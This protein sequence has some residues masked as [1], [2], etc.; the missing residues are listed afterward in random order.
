M[1]K[2]K[3]MSKEYLKW[4]DDVFDFYQSKCVVCGSGEEINVHHILPYQKFP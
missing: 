3:R 4:R 1:N 2:I